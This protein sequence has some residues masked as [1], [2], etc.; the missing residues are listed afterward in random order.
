M[1]MIMMD[2]TERLPKV[3]ELVREYYPEYY[4]WHTY[5]ASE[6]VAI[7]KIDEEWGVLH[8]MAATPLVID[9]VD[10]KCC[11]TLFQSLKFK[12]TSVIQDVY[13]RNNKKWAQHWEKQGY[14][15]QDWGTIFIDIL[16]FCLQMKYEQS[17]LFRQELERS[18]GFIIVEDETGRKSTTYGAKL[19]DD[20][21][22][23]SNLLG[24]LLME[25][26]DKGKLE[27]SLPL[28]ALEYI[29]VLKR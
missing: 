19:K 25:L 1:T 28:D 5:R 13:R 23:G 12:D 11:E 27:Y 10:F 2:K 24:R 26:R 15:R 7:H 17:A 9:G 20:V 21:F 14:R 18:R 8:N 22:E 29:K 6:C 3:S 16:K 4:Q